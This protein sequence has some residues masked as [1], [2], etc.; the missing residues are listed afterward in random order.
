M[1]SATPGSLKI[2]DIND[3]GVINDKDR[4]VIGNPFP[5]ATWGI[6][7]T[8]RW[9]GFDLYFL[10]QGVSG[11]D[12][13]NGDGYYTESK[14]FNRNYV[15]D[16]WISAEYPGDGRT[17]T[18]G[19]AGI[20][21]EFTDYMIEDGSFV[22]LRD[23][24]LGYTF[25]KKKLK[26]AGL[27]SL[28]LYASGQNLLYFWG[29]SYRGINPEAR[30]TTG[31]YSSHW[32]TDTS[33]EDSRYSLPSISDLNLTSNHLK[34]YSNETKTYIYRQ[35]VRLC[36]GSFFLRPQHYTG[37]LYPRRS[38]YKNEAE[39]NTAVIGCYGGMQAPLNIEWT[40]T[41]LRADNTRMNSNSSTNDAFLQQQALDLGTMDASNAN[42]RTYWE[43]TYSNINSCNN[44]LAPENLA[45][46]ANEKKR[47]QFE[48]E[49]RFIRAYHYFN[50]VRLFGP[51]FIVTEELSVAEAMKK[52][53]SSVEAT[54][55]QII[56]DLQRSVDNLEGITYDIADLGRVTQAAAQ[57]LLAKVYLT[58]GK[59]TEAKSLLKA[60]VDV[61][62]DQLTV[63]Y[64]DVFD[65][66]K[67][68]N[69]EIIFAIRYKSGSLGIG[70]P[71][72]NTFAPTK[73][74][75]NVVTV[76]V[77]DVT[78]RQQ[79]FSEFIRKVICVRMPA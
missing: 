35:S 41:E 52:D 42:I 37:L 36:I 64:S 25:D 17:P 9:K 31:S 66:S 48:G 33:V 34:T 57:S 67:E 7:N 70:S 3:D 29:K 76:T 14:K 32:S 19:S 59:Y 26:K 30:V 20:S 1:A 47:A 72:A 62:G 12:V 50:L 13:F 10:I 24:V 51:T 43:A 5:K 68:M 27:N 4:T 49:V 23:V 8:F 55:K 46:V 60:V 78:I 73:S 77:T 21:W 40:L 28:R 63:S 16:R 71:F 75:A 2:V 54:Y 69:D 38:F 79:K 6:S 18:V 39:M 22:A 44:V 11:L 53:R 45:V 61:K 58:L 56:D 65:I 15:K 74:G